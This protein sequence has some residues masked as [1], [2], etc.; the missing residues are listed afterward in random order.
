M[1]SSNDDLCRTG[2]IK[3]R[4]VSSLPITSRAES[5]KESDDAEDD[6]FMMFSTSPD[7]LRHENPFRHSGRTRDITSV[8]AKT[9]TE[10]MAAFSEY[11]IPINRQEVRPSSA[12]I[13]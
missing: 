11:A 9:T 10:E 8:F 7:L 1:A 6:M 12:S 2:T 4:P 3:A 13:M 5:Q